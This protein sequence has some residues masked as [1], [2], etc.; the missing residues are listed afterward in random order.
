MEVLSICMCWGMTGSEAHAGEVSRLLGAGRSR[1]REA[2]GK[3]TGQEVA[4]MVPGRHDGW[5]EGGARG[6]ETDQK[7]GLLGSPKPS[8]SKP[9]PLVLP[10][11]R[12]ALS[13]RGTTFLSPLH[14]AGSYP[15]PWVT[16]QVAAPPRRLWV[17]RD[18]VSCSP[19]GVSPLAG[20]QPPWSRTTHSL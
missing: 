15:V 17:E 13:H 8:P 2:Q 20:S 11:L 18:T 3:E 14:L 16:A 5:N 4:L 6:M 12:C 9:C 10:C 19:E 7:P 1:G